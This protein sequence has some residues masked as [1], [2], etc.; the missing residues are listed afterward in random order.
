MQIG[1]ICDVVFQAY[2][3]G[4]CDDVLKWKPLSMN[5]VDFKLKVVTEEGQG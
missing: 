4:R 2:M 5:S 3:A 1:F